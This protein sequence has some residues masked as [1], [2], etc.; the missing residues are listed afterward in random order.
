MFLNFKLEKQ[1]KYQFS[2]FKPKQIS[3]IRTLK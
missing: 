1:A 2:N 3:E